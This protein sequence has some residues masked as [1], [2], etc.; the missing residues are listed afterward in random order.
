MQRS[1]T[2]LVDF[3]FELPPKMQSKA[4]TLA[5]YIRAADPQRRPI[6]QQLHD[7]VVGEHPSALS[8]MQYGMPTYQIGS[9]TLAFNAQKQYYS[10]YIDPGILDDFRTDLKQYSTW[11]KLY[12]LYPARRRSA[13]NP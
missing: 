2:R 12:S 10:L 6:L 3:G 4:K 5:D 8:S 9:R 11:E 13:L 7:L 1:P